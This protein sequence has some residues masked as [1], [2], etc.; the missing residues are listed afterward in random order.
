[1]QVSPRCPHI[2][3]HLPPPHTH[4]HAANWEH[5]P[6]VADMIQL[7]QKGLHGPRGEEG[8]REGEEGTLMAMGKEE[9]Q[10]NKFALLMTLEDEH[11]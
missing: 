9:Q 2:P 5:H 10:M 1:M 7:Q 6:E 3:Y 8:E 4:T 11:T